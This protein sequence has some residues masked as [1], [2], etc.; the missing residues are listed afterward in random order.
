MADGEWSGNLFENSYNWLCSSIWWWKW[1][2][3]PFFFLRNC[4]I[5]RIHLVLD[6]RIRAPFA[7]LWTVWCLLGFFIVV[8]R[9]EGHLKYMLKCIKYF[10]LKINL[11][12]QKCVIS[13]GVIKHP[14]V[15]E[16]FCIWVSINQSNIKSSIVSNSSWQ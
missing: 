9:W 10:D 15:N 11:S 14:G 2:Q 13:S 6:P 7:P 4:S 8:L 1:Y 5:W 3:F 16:R 12:Q